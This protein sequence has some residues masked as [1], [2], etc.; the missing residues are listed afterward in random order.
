M[1]FK[2]L[3]IGNKLGVGFGILIVLLIG[4]GAMAILNMSKVSDSSALLTDEF[5]PEVT[6]SN[7]V[8]SDAFN[9]L[10]NIR[11]YVFTGNTDYLN[12]GQDYLRKLKSSLDEAEQL[13]KKSTQLEGLG[14]AI[15]SSKEA[16]V[17]YENN[18]QETEQVHKN[19][20]QEK[21]NMDAAAT[22][23]TRI[24]DGYHEDLVVSLRSGK[25]QRAS[26]NQLE[27]LA[28]IVNEVNTIRVSNFKAQAD[29]S[30]QSLEAIAANFSKVDTYL[31]QLR[32]SATTSD[33]KR[34][35][36]KISDATIAY[37]KAMESFIVGWDKRESLTTKRESLGN[38]V[39]DDAEKVAADGISSAQQVSDESMTLLDF[40]SNTMLYGVIFAVLIGIIFAIIITR[41]ITTPILK[42]VTFASQIAGGD[43][44][45]TVDIDQKDEVGELANALRNMIA[46]LREVVSSV[47]M[48]ADNISAASYQLSSTSQEMSQGATEQASSAEEVSSSMEQMVANIQQ[49]TDNAQQT[50]KMALKAAEDVQTGSSAVNQTVD[51]MRNIAEKVTIIGE[52]ARQT[53]ILALNAAV[54]AARAGE[55]GKGFAVVAAEVRKLAERS[56]AAAEEIDEV[57]K[58]SVDVSDRAGKLLEKIV[59]DIQKTARLVQEISAASTE[60]N[61]GAEQVNGALQQLNQVT[62]QNAAAS[63]EMATSSEELS[64]QA[65]QLKELIGFFNVGHQATRARKKQ[66]HQVE[67]GHLKRKES[68]NGQN[69]K[70]TSPSPQKENGVKI[71]LDGDMGD[72][73]SFETF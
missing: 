18:L 13:A 35:V 31:N 45:A 16:V 4:L 33:A 21:E 22:D 70:S 72:D 8:E 49:N 67:I 3:K 55:H 63:E 41:A 59:P 29:N 42:G 26:L 38:V 36:D 11:G 48:G 60:Q 17:S 47:L 6:M 14:N 20:E 50:D 12:K 39:L 37:R 61:S 9:M 32:K 56:R 71:E 51:S 52:I 62:Q 1:N 30:V 40:S 28:D 19:L 53:N 43:L 27:L 44:T 34:Q 46:K 64:N 58:S 25:V 23:F 73:S 15:K 5:I 69:G 68:G 24:S 66:N 2:N 65:E 7:D 57:S 10:Y 54:E